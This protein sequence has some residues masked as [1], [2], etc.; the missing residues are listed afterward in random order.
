MKQIIECPCKRKV[1]S[2]NTVSGL[3]VI[4][5]GCSNVTEMLKKCFAA[6]PLDGYKCPE[7]GVEG[8]THMRNEAGS[9]PPILMIQ[10]TRV[11]I[12]HRKDRTPIIY[13][14][15]LNENTLLKGAKHGHKYQ[16]MAVCVHDGQAASSGHYYDYIHDTR[17]KRWFHFNDAV[18]KPIKPPGVETEDDTTKPTSDMRGC[19]LL[20]YR[21]DTDIDMD[22]DE[23]P[24]PS[25]PKRAFVIAKRVR[26]L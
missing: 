14:R 19:Y 8:I 25:L 22:D 24:Y 21:R 3:H 7:C 11:S 2:E 1:V 16:L 23:I 15:E 12:D 10:I 20:L 17:R 13:P 5:E 26:K 9:L 4:P 18:V 6:A